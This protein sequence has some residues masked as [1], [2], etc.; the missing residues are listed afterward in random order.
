MKK[1][2]LLFLTT[3]CLSFNVFAQSDC[4]TFL[5]IP[6]D[7]DIQTFCK[8]LENKGFTNISDKLKSN[9][10]NSIY[11]EMLNNV[12]AGEF[13]CYMVGIQ[14]QT[15]KNKVWRVI[16]IDLAAS[17]DNNIKHRFN[18]TFNQLNSNSKYQYYSGSEIPDDINITYEIIVNGKTYWACFYT[19]NTNGCVK[20]TYGKEQD[21]Y[22]L[23]LY[24]ENLNNFTNGDDL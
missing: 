10:S 19:K 1:F 18:R 4:I 14:V 24:Y 9:A 23:T 5:G 2:I 15:I 6:I 13:N 17:D 7:N 3:I 20:L 8:E 16:V 22:R 21:G 11:A 12:Y